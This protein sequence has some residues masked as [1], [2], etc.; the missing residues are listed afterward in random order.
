MPS[1]G[2][3]AEGSVR[4]PLA[5][6]R[7]ASGHGSKIGFHGEDITAVEGLLSFF[8]LSL[9]GVVVGGVMFK[10]AD[11]YLKWIT[12]HALEQTLVVLSLIYGPCP[13]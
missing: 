9:G 2:S 8:K 7:V 6:L 1:A 3:L 10:L 5:Y 11:E 4:A 12:H 13:S